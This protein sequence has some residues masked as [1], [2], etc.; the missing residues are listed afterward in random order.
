MRS[1]EITKN[2]TSP[3]EVNT[4]HRGTI[5]TCIRYAHD[6]RFR[7]DGPGQHD[8]AVVQPHVPGPVRAPDAQAQARVQDAPRGARPEEQVSDGRSVQTPEPRE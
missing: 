8:A 1:A 6:E 2:P 5:Y 7:V 3:H 4:T